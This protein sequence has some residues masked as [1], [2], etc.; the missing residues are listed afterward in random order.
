MLEAFGIMGSVYM[1]RAMNRQNPSVALVNNGSEE[2]KSTS[3]YVEAHARMKQNKQMC[4][5][6]NI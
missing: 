3:V 5:V 4:F 6:G 1:E 2:N